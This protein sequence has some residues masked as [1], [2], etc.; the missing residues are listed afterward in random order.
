MA[1]ARRAVAAGARF[2]VGNAATLWRE[3]GRIDGVEVDGERLPAG[4]CLAAAGAATC[5]S[6]DP[7]GSWQPIRPSW[8]VNVDLQLRRPPRAVIEEAGVETAAIAGP[9]TPAADEVPSTFSLVTAKGSSS[10]GSTFLGWH[11]DAELTGPLL[12]D[13]GSRFVP[14]P[15]PS[16]PFGPSLRTAAVD[17]W[18]PIAGPVAGLERALRRFRSWSVGDLGWGPPARAWS[19]TSSASAGGHPAQ[20]AAGRFGEVP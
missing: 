5:G 2:L 8:G 11:P 13:R 15:R 1:F 7:S 9:T 19:A 17:R 20:L 10:L 6:I 12:R 16:D 4:A 3:G 14:A 18:T